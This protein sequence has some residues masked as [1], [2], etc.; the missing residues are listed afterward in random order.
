MAAEDI[1]A[2]NLLFQRPLEPSFTSRDDGNS[3]LTLPESFF[4]DNYKDNSK[5]E[6]ESRFGDNVQTKIPLKEIPKPN[7]DFTSVVPI[8]RPFSLFI[9]K[10]K[11]CAGQL[12]DLFLKAPDPKSFISLSAYTKDRVNPFLF[13]YCFSVACQHRKDIGNTIQVPTVVE[14]FPQN[15]VEPGV[16]RDARAEGSLISQGNRTK[17]NIPQNY[18]ASDR[19]EEQRLFYFR[20]DIGVNS[21]HWHWH[22]VYPDSGPLEIVNKD[23]R[24]ELFYYM[25]HQII[26]RYNTERLCNHLAKLR[27]FN[28]LDDPIKEGYFPKILNSLNN[29]TYPA[30]PNN[31]KLFD[32]NRENNVIQVGDVKRW[33]DRVHEAIDKGFATMTQGQNVPL[34]EVRGIDILGNMIEASALTPNRQYYGNLHNMGHNLIALCHDPDSRHLEEFGVMGDVSTAMRDPVFYRWHGFIDGI[35][36]KYKDLLPPYQANDLSNDGIVVNGIECKIMST[37]RTAPNQLLTY[38]QKSDVDLAAGLDFGPNGNV[39]AEFTHLQHPPFEYSINV[40]NNSGTQ[41]QGTCRLFLCVKQDERGMDLSY[42][43][44]RDFAIELDKFLV[45][46]KPGQ[47]VIKRRSDESSVTI[48]FDRSFRRLGEKFQPKDPTEKSIFQFC[49]CGWPQHLLIPKGQKE[50]MQ[51]DLFVMISNYADDA[52]T[53]T[54]SA[55]SPCG[56][57]YSFCGLKDKLYPDK[58]AMGFPF[59]R[60]A[61]AETLDAFIAPYPNMKKQIVTITFQDFLVDRTK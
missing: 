30:R 43:D 29:R 23:R 46:M 36:K 27:P 54:N 26:A 57:A 51:F 9:D 7:L 11:E 40:S 45:N 2:I 35:F 31:S 39:F 44:Q 3:S 28:N 47:N 20:E 25:H 50:G 38:W 22:L 1:K 15:F 19:E 10:H 48:P 21:H 58:R 18:T 32:V 12:I 41:K 16:F 55:V 37:G 24:G 33:V 17:V 59:D 60:T 34:D 49:G 13:Q 14:L 4:T 42:N 6:F 61:S 52:V 8:K 53:Q 56:D 5:I